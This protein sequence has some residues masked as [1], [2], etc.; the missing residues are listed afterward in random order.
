M[1]GI[2]RLAGKDSPIFNGRFVVS[3]RKPKRL[4]KTEEK[5][6]SGEQSKP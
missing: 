4:V 2:S 3:G 1:K 5:K 6:K